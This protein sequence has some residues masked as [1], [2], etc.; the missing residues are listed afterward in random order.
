MRSNYLTQKIEDVI[1]I[2]HKY[3]LQK[4]MFI[5]INFFF[6]LSELNMRVKLTK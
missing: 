3:I 4:E 6:G 5:Y 1:K 2:D